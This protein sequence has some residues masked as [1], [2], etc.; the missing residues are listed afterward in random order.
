MILTTEEAPS[1]TD[2]GWSVDHQ[3]PP[4]KLGERMCQGHPWWRSPDTFCQCG[5]ERK[6]VPRA[7]LQRHHFVS[8][9]V[10]ILQLHQTC[11]CMAVGTEALRAPES[12]TGLV[13]QTVRQTQRECLKSH[14]LLTTETYEKRNHRSVYDETFNRFFPGLHPQS[15]LSKEHAETDCTLHYSRTSISSSLSGRPPQR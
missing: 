11:F 2:S 13:C 5:A 4:E 10:V 3:A 6:R 7:V 9:C 8:L 15:P 12:I 1:T 14:S